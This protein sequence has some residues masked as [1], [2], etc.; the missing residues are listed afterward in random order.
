MIP[1]LHGPPECQTGTS[2]ETHNGGYHSQS[3]DYN[4]HFES[5][6]A[7]STIEGLAGWWTKEMTGTSKMGG[8]IAFRFRDPEGDIMGAMNMEVV[9]Q[10]T[11]KNV[12]WRC[13][14]GPKE[15]VGTDVTFDLTQDGD[16]T[17]VLFGHRNWR[18]AAGFTAH[19]SMK[20]GTFLLSLK[21]LVETGNDKP[22]PDDMKI[23]NWN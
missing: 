23:D 8:T 4:T 18:E 15:W 16:Y 10:N 17:I 22:A 2:K 5:H 14:S 11:N 19:C 6:A 7:L 9:A 12:H 21:N 3:R 13:I 20:W 1:I